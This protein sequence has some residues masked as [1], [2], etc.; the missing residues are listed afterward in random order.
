[1][2]KERRRLH[3]SVQGL[4]RFHEGCFGEAFHL[5]LGP[6]AAAFAASAS[7]LPGVLLFNSKLYSDAVEVVRRDASDI[8]PRPVDS[9]PP[10]PPVACASLSSWALPSWAWH[11]ALVVSRHVRRDEIVFEYGVGGV[12]LRAAT[13]SLR[14]DQCMTAE[15]LGAVLVSLVAAY[16]GLDGMVVPHDLISF[17]GVKLPGGIVM[18]AGDWA[19]AERAQ[20]L[21][22]LSRIPGGGA[23]DPVVAFAQQ[24]VDLADAGP[25]EYERWPELYCPFRVRDIIGVKHNGTWYMLVVPVYYEFKAEAGRAPAEH[26]ENYERDNAAYT[27]GGFVAT[28]SWVLTRW[29]GGPNAKADEAAL[30]VA[31]IR[32]APNVVH[33]CSGSCKVREACVHGI[34]NNLAPKYLADLLGRWCRC[35]EAKKKALRVVHACAGSPSFLLSRFDFNKK[36]YVKW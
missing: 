32:M 27:K 12:P 7:P 1:M 10:P 22:F 4:T 36:T 17:D 14:A 30:P 15:R 19:L 35:S 31:V 28:G 18:K 5:Q 2:R 9:A 11:Q 6:A 21:S 23:S 24:H 33:K 20:V 16:P 3:G 8:A 25:E 29:L 34:Y 13:T 26:L